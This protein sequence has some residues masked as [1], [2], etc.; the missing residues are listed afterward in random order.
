MS[1]RPLYTDCRSLPYSSTFRYH[2]CCIYSLL[3]RRCRFCLWRADFWFIFITKR[4]GV[5]ITT[6]FSF[7]FLKDHTIHSINVLFFSISAN[8]FIMLGKPADMAQTR[9]PVLLREAFSSIDYRDIR[10]LYQLVTHFSHP[11]WCN[12]IYKG[13]SPQTSDIKVAAQTYSRRKIT[14]MWNNFP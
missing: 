8:H 2:I 14:E 11:D 6:M 3:I 9:H 4:R 5:Q 12:Y 1:S 13:Y 7:H 10:K